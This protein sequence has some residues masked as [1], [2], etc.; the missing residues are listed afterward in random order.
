MSLS[1]LPPNQKNDLVVSLA[2]LLLEDAGSV[3][4]AENISAVVAATKN[5][6]PAYYPTLFAAMLEKSDGCA[7]FCQMS[8]GDR[9][10]SIGS[11][12]IGSYVP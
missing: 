10:G 1:E 8:A 9:I 6:V 3:L 12:R 5:E 2:A 7:Q 11:G 4:T